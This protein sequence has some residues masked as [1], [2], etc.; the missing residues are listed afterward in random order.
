MKLPRLMPR[1]Q[2]IYDIVP[3][4]KTAADIGTDHAYIPVCLCLSGKCHSAIASDIRKG[5]LERAM[6]TIEE[7]GANTVETRLGS[8]LKTIK[9]NEAQ[10][11]I[12]A[13]MGGIL[14]ADIIKASKETA[15]S[16]S[17]LILQPMT[18]APELREYLTENGFKI[19]KEYLVREEEKIYTVIS[20]RV[21]AD[22]PYTK[23]ELYMGRYFD[24]DELYR[25][26]R[27]I[28]LEKLDRQINGLS[29]SENEENKKRLASLINLKEMI[30]NENL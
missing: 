8:G 26:Y 17:K 22:L 6:A 25:D 28:R 30:E 27:K 29:K 13:G 3:P 7:Y 21:G 9:P 2:K 10:A 20:A 19:E 14:I 15:L 1:L 18:A 5:P 23:A 4:C 11:I 16:A 24:K 12:I